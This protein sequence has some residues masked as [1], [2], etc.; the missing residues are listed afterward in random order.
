MLIRNISIDGVARV[1]RKTI[2]QVLL[3]LM[4]GG[5]AVY[6]QQVADA[7]LAASPDAAP[8][9]SAPVATDTTA[10]AA[11]AA[12][13]ATAAVDTSSVSPS[14]ADPAP[15]SATAM[16]S[17]AVT[18]AKPAAPA[19][20]KAKKG[21][22]VYTGPTEI[23]VLPPK[24][25]LDGEGKQRVDP[26]GKLMFEI[27]VKQIRD[28]KGHP[29]FDEK[30]TPVYQTADNLG[31]TEKG[32]KIAA[33][34]IKPPKMTP[35]S[36]VA[37]T[38]TVDGWTGKARLNYD[39]ADL[40]YMYIY[41]PGVGTT[42]VSQNPFP[43]AKEVPLGFK[44]KTLSITVD[45]HPIQLY[46]EKPLLKK[47]QAAWVVVD[48]GFSLPSKFPVFG[49]GTTTKLPYAWPGS[50]NTLASKG[51]FQPP[52]LPNEVRPTLLLAACPAGMMR[53]PVPAVLPGQKIPDQPC[54]PIVVPSAST[55]SA[56]ASTS[57]AVTPASPAP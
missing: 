50:K 13:P 39:I 42:I 15:T 57:A 7:T 19:A 27:P 55:A 46:S 3:G 9:V 8:A 30:G 38:L 36:I 14:Q 32:K 6:A 52:P 29:V 49:Y 10:Q 20:P 53:K 11:V 22:E 2:L 24:P 25:M 43:G 35:V 4:G 51:V 18:P 41:A 21:K 23:V 17:Q 48:R 26:D 40:K 47:K 56:P 34:K 16:P 45:G 31:Y 54:V 37:G 44:D 5:V 1:A 28:K 12:A 33:K